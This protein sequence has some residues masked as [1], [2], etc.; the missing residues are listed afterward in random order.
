MIFLFL[1]GLV[2]GGASM[3]AFLAFGNPLFILYA[4]VNLGC[5]LYAFVELERR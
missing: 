3:A 1:W 5:A 2:W 4:V